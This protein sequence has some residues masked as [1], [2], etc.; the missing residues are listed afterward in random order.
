MIYCLSS[1]TL[2]YPLSGVLLVDFH[3]LIICTLGLLLFIYSTLENNKKIIFL[4]P[5]IFVIGFLCK[6]IPA[7]Y[8]ILTIIVISLI[9]THKY[10]TF[11]LIYYLSLGTIFALMSFALLLFFYKINLD[12]F[13]IQYIYFALSIFSNSQNES[14]LIQLKEAAKIKYLLMFFFFILYSTYY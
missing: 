12:N 3:S 10:K 1:A 5:T 2:M 9:Y 4:V 6:Q 7:A 8:F 13:I 14:L 11:W